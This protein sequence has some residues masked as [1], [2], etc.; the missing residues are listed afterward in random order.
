MWCPLNRLHLTAQLSFFN[1]RISENTN[2]FKYTDNP[3]AQ[4]K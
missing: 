1:H 4:N 3:G 2:K